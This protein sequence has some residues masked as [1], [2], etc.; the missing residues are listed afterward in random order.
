MLLVLGLHQSNNKVVGKLGVDQQRH[1]SLVDGKNQIN[2]HYSTVPILDH[3]S[4]LILPSQ[5]P[6]PASPIQKNTDMMMPAVFDGAAN[7]V[8]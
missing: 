6:V 8:L 3:P 2:A 1:Q 4:F 5:A 7:T